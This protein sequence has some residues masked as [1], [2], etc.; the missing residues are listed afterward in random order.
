MDRTVLQALRARFKRTG[1]V[2]VADGIDLIDALLASAPKASPKP[3]TAKKA[4]RKK[5]A[6]KKG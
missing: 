5:A 3:K 2:T 4:A 6:R 1:T